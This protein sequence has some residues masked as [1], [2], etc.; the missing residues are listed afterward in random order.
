MVPPVPTSVAVYGA[1]FSPAGSDEIEMLG[2]ADLKQRYLPPAIRGEKIGCL[3]ITEPEAG[4]D[5]ASIRTKAIREAEDWLAAE[6][7][8]DSLLKAA[9]GGSSQ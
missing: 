7:E 9:R 3:G 6:S 8:I 2:T 1:V 4:S 5:V